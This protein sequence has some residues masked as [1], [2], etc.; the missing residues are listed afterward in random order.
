MSAAL[1]VF[2]VLALAGA[3]IGLALVDHRSI[4]PITGTAALIL[5]IAALTVAMY[6]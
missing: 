2:F 3:L 4:P 6:R 5:T 1:G